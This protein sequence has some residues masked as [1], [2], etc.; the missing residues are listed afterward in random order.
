MIRAK[1]Q[2]N[3]WLDRKY[4]EGDEERMNVKRKMTVAVS[5]QL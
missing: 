5:L 3:Q 4:V 1:W 2:V